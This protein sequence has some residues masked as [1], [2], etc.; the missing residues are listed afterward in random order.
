MI[1]VAHFQKVEVHIQVDFTTGHAI[2]PHEVE[3]SYK[4]MFEERAISVM[5]YNL[6][7]IFSEKV[8][9]VLSR[10]ITGTRMRDYY[11][12]YILVTLYKESLLRN[13][14]LDAIKIKAKERNT[15]EHIEDY[16]THLKNI[17]NSMEIQK[18][19]SAYQDDYSGL[20]CAVN[21]QIGCSSRGF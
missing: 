8:E 2:I 18:L 20:N 11:D 12:I 1:L 15:L 21:A 9:A 17:S 16:K 6:N 10:N 7:T 14:I 19:W 5:A 13:E 4:L 3:Y